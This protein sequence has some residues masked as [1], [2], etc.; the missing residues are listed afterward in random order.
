MYPYSDCLALTNLH[1]YLAAFHK[2]TLP[3]SIALDFL[4]GHT[5]DANSI[6]LLYLA[7][8]TGLITAGDNSTIHVSKTI[9]GELLNPYPANLEHVARAIHAVSGSSRATWQ[10]YIQQART[11]L[12]IARALATL[13]EPL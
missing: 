7:Y 8:Q 1:A 6:R 12:A 9:P 4:R 5:H 11:S 13:P 10:T 3:K 2:P